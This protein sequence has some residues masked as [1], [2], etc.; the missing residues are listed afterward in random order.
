M[1]LFSPLYH[2]TKNKIVDDV[3]RQFT[4]ASLKNEGRKKGKKKKEMIP[5]LTTSLLIAYQDFIITKLII[6][7]V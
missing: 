1:A 2:P 4:I 5:Q 3:N 6:V 7:F